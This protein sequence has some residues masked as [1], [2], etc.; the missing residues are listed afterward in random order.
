MPFSSFRPGPPTCTANYHASCPLCQPNQPLMIDSDRTEQWHSGCSLNRDSVHEQLIRALINRTGETINSQND[1]GNRDMHPSVSHLA[2]FDMDRG[3][4]GLI[5]MEGVLDSQAQRQ[6]R[7]AP[8]LA[9]SMTIRS[10]RKSAFHDLS[11]WRYFVNAAMTR[12][13]GSRGSMAR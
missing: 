4:D 3:S 6:Q 10:H 13:N 5:N 8:R 9:H 7:P 1:T 2:R 12:A 11:S